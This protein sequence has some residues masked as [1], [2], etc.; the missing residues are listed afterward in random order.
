MCK[1]FE[2]F[3]KGH[4]ERMNLAQQV[5]VGI[6]AKHDKKRRKILG[7][8]DDTVGLIFFFNQTR[9]IF[10]QGVFFQ[11]EDVQEISILQKFG[12]QSIDENPDLRTAYPVHRVEFEGEDLVKTHVANCYPSQLGRCLGRKIF[13]VDGLVDQ[14]M[15]SQNSGTRTEAPLER[16]ELFEGFLYFSVDL[17]L[18]KIVLEKLQ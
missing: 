3:L 11:L 1:E 15:Y 7:E 6:K 4:D 14:M 9:N 16:R 5:G 8:L 17:T 10:F 2:D 12:F 18:Q 13:G